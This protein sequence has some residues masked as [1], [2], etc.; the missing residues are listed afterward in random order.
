[1]V[2]ATQYLQNKRIEMPNFK[3]VSVASAM[4]LDVDVSKAHDGLYDIEL[5]YQIYK[6]IISPNPL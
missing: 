5:T 3:L 1:M 4:G 6:R 2:L